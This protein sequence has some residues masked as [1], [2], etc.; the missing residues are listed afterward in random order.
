MTIM[1][2]VIGKTLCRSRVLAFRP[3]RRPQRITRVKLFSSIKD[4]QTKRDESTTSTA[5]NDPRIQARVKTMK[6]N[7]KSRFRQHV[8]PLARQYQQPTELSEEWPNDVFDIVQ[9]RD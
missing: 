6:R 4:E 9:N 7:N 1:A 5:W 2:L 3:T 8:N